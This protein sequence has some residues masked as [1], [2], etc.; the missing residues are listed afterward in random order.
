MSYISENDIN[1]F[2]KQKRHYFNK[3]DIPNIQ[4]S[5]SLCEITLDELDA[6]PLKS[7]A[8]GLFLSVTLGLFGI[9]RFYAGNNI[10][11]ILKLLSTGWSGIGWVVDWFLIKRAIR[12]RNYDNLDEYLTEIVIGE[13]NHF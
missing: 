2:L 9:D 11:G 5:L 6:F 13:D 10:A 4:R 8:T 3:A 1:I 7:P 12:K